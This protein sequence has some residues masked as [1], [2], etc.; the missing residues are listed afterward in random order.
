MPKDKPTDMGCYNPRLDQKENGFLPCRECTNFNPYSVAVQLYKLQT[1][2]EFRE[3]F[4]FV[5]VRRS[6]YERWRSINQK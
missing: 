2:K 4:S 1:C 6:T 3:K 5:R